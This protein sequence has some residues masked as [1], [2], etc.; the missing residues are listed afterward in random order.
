VRERFTSRSGELIRLPRLPLE[1]EVLP[2]LL[3][4][5][6]L[7]GDRGLVG[8]LRLPLRA[9]EAVPVLLEPRG[10]LLP[11]NACWASTPP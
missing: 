4:E 3:R 1:P 10:D 9:L 11:C 8:L 7:L 5:L 6:V 2:G